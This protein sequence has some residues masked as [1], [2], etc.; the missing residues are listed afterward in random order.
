VVTTNQYDAAN[1]LTQ[2][3][4]RSA[5]DDLLGRY[6]YALDGVGNR[7]QATE[8]ISTPGQGLVTTAI[9]YTYDSLYRL[10]EADYSS[11]ERFKYV[12]DAAGNMTTLTATITNTVVTTKT[13]DAAN[14]LHTVTAGGVARTLDWSGAGELLRDGDDTYTWDAAGRLV[15]AT[16]EGVKS[17]Y[18]YLGDGARISMTVGSE[19]TTYT[20]DL[21]APLV[22]VLVAHQSTNP[23]STVYLY[24]VTR[25]GEYDDAWRYHLADHL[26]SVRSVVD[27][28]GG[29]VAT[30]AYQPYGSPLSTAGSTDSIYGFTGEQTDPTGLIYLRARY[31]DG[32]LGSFLQRDTWEGDPN[33]PISY[34]AWLYGYANPIQW[35]D[36]TGLSPKVVCENI[37]GY[38]DLLFGLRR[39][40]E[41]GKGM[42][43]ILPCLKPGKTS[44]EV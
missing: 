3:A 38:M 13:Y 29:V 43:T 44:S 22:Q 17:R 1:R 23:Q 6:V 26:G 12:Y 32:I 5:G 25:I 15:S 39:N 37:P 28:A 19:T 16:V 8:T 4:H 11:G 24:G 20:L 2:I 34:N 30:R 14:R 42:I 10:S 31:L 33:R 35:V 40:C 21:A 36:R 41:I 18:A 7:V 27:E 9:T